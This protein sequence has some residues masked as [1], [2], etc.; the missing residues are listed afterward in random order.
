MRKG[1]ICTRDGD[2]GTDRGEGG[3]MAGGGR[4][5][6][7]EGRVLYFL[8]IQILACVGLVSWLSK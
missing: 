7:V 3:E 1:G 2:G 6:A 5:A 4:L 8:K